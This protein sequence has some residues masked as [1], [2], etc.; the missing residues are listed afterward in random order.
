VS[1]AVLAR[2]FPIRLVISWN[3]VYGE[4]LSNFEELGEEGEIWSVSARFQEPYPN[5]GHPFRFGVESIE[6]MVDWILQCLPP[7]T[8][9]S[10]LEVGS[11]N[12]TLLFALADAGYTATRLSGIDYS[13]DAVKLAKSI[14]LTRK[15]QHITFNLCDFLKEDPP[16]LSHMPQTIDQCAWD[17]LLDKGTFDA[18]AL[19]EKDESGR[20]PAA[21]YPERIAKLLKPGGRFLITCA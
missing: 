21:R 11:G 12:G 17:M 3:N 14:A 19:G 2:V 9:A 15:S 5:L 7:S 4:E 18:I 10:I 8:D 16:L 13:P 20:S 6:K 1:P